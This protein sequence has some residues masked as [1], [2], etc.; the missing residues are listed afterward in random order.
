M[1]ENNQL[2]L[3]K[4]WK[5]NTIIKE[6]LTKIK[7]DNIETQEKQVAENIK[8]IMTSLLQEDK[9]VELLPWRGTGSAITKGTMSEDYP[10]TKRELSK[11]IQSVWMTKG[12]VP[13][14][15]IN[16]AHKKKDM[17]IKESKAVK[18][19]KGHETSI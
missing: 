18:S 13:Y 9:G 5:R 16:I 11:Y 3:E 4:R 10:V 15:R 8:T 7:G 6:K 17:F 1:K 2:N 19:L 12:R 14:I